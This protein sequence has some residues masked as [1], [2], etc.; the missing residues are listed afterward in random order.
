[1]CIVESS[2]DA[3][4]SLSTMSDPLSLFEE[5]KFKQTNQG[6]QKQTT[7]SAG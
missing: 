7:C 3:C 4:V 1:M 2:V 5:F 6:L